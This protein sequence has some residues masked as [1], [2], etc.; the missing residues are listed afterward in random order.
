WRGEAYRTFRGEGLEPRSDDIPGARCGECGLKVQNAALRAGRRGQG[1]AA[2][3]GVL[4]RWNRTF[5]DR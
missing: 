5:L 4:A 1:L 2:W 3:A